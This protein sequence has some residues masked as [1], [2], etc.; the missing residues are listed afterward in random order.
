MEQDVLNIFSQ[1]SYL[2][3][4]GTVT[5]AVFFAMTALHELQSRHLDGLVYLVLAVFFVAA[6]FIYL[7]E[8]PA[9][10]MALLTDQPM[11]VWLWLSLFF[12][13]A[14]ICLFILFGVFRLM[15]SSTQA[16]LVKIF[17]GLTLLCYLYMLGPDWPVDVKGILT[18]VYSGVW[19]DIGLKTAV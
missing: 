1:G 7:S 9:K 4:L 8:L 17:M 19:F 5:A 6:H 3:L 11:S 10:T 13:P 15:F 14:L 16:G 18:L 2:I 12:A